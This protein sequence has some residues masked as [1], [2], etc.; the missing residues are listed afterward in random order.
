MTLFTCLADGDYIQSLYSVLEQIYLCLGG[1]SV[2]SINRLGNNLF[3]FTRCIF[4]IET[5]HIIKLHSETQVS[6]R[7]G[8]WGGGGGIP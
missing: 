8:M 6:V 3:M 4:H 2:T 7:L 1:A 5:H